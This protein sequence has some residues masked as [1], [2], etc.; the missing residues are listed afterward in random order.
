MPAAN[1]RHYNHHHH[2]RN[3]LQQRTTPSPL[4][5]TQRDASDEDLQQSKICNNAPHHLFQREQNHF[6]SFLSRI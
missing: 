3:Q 4:S 6:N 1:H 5:P 2:H